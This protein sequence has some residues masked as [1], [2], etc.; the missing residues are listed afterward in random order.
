MNENTQMT[1]TSASPSE[2]GRDRTGEQEIVLLPPVDIYEDSDGITLIADLPGV[3]REQLDIHVDRDALQID[4]RVRMD[5]P[6]GIQALYAD[7]QSTRYRRDFSLSP[8]LDTD[9]ID[10]VLK[11][12][13][14]NLRIPKRAEH[15]PRKIEIATN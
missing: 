15:R 9:R 11:D 5:L 13:V 14:L 8:E 10:A 6:E 12:G 2:P 3:G 7:V 4:A 1:T